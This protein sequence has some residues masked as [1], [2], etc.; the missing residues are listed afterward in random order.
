M[1]AT[2]GI[3]LAIIAML[4]WGIGDFLIQ[5]STRAIGNWETL[6]VITAFGAVVLLP[7]VWS[8]IPTLFDNYSSL[9]FA[10]VFS[11]VI[12]FIAAL[13]EFEALRQGKL[14]V[15]EPIWSLEIPTA[16]ILAYLI[17]GEVLTVW[18]IVLMV[19]LIIGLVG[20]SFRGAKIKARH[21][22]EKGALISVL[23]A[24]M[25]GTANFFMGFSGRI[26]DTLL[27]NF[28][29]CVVMAVVTIIYIAAKG[30][31]KKMIADIK[32]RPKMLTLM[33]IFDNV[34]W[35]AFVAAMSLAPIGIVVALT[36]SYIVIV[37][38]LGI[39]VNK[40]KLRHRQKIGLFLALFSAIM[41]ALISG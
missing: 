21:F 36:E 5:R 41:L 10:L 29:A 18:Q 31:T 38:L 26:S 32:A 7:F 13:L 8:D 2:T 15:V 33:S 16:A 20:I 17:L 12:I 19:L 14:S 1:T 3:I 6:F 11:G 34:A 9:L 39:M 37:V 4:S 40:E 27:T 28:V 23:A 25:M 22:L 24:F 35:I 30:R